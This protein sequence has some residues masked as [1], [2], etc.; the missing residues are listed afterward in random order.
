[1]K[2][3]EFVRWLAVMGA[4]LIAMTGARGETTNDYFQCQ[5]QKYTEQV[6]VSGQYPGPVTHTGTCTDEKVS[7]CNPMRYDKTSLG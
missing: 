2:G 3:K 5:P 1:M 7:Y 4:T 6:N